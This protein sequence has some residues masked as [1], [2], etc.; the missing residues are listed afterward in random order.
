MNRLTTKLL[1]VLAAAAASVAGAQ[2]ADAPG[3]ESAEAALTSFLSAAKAQ[4]LHAMAAV[5][6]DS[7]GPAADKFDRLELQKREL[8][9]MKLL[10]QDSARVITR[11][12]GIESSV[13]LRVELKRA[14]NAVTV[15]F[16][17]VKGP[18]D[19][20]FIKELEM[21]KLQGLCR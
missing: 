14:T 3:A 2:K 7:K 1:V 10:C 20:W 15:E 19:R 5:W 11:S 16:T 21:E 13:V 6:G 9:M 12:P 4:D 17:A 18:K 8:I